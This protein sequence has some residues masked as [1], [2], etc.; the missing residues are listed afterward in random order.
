[1][2]PTDAQTAAAL[3]TGTVSVVHSYARVQG[4]SR[5][6]YAAFAGKPVGDFT[7]LAWQAAI[8]NA[9]QAAWSS[10]QNTL[11]SAWAKS[12]R[13]LIDHK[14]APAAHFDAYCKTVAQNWSVWPITGE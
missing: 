5:Q 3:G 14:L 12:N 11:L 8:R 1:M 9:Y 7:G 4:T 2:A 10:N 13:S 6:E